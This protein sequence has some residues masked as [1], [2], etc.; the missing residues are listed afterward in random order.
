MFIMLH[1]SRS[2]IKLQACWASAKLPLFGKFSHVN[3][4][5]PLHVSTLPDCACRFICPG[6]VHFSVHCLMILVLYILEL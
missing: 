3:L 1:I 6:A 2:R 5:L 4:A